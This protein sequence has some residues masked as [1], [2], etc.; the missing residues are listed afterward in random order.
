MRFIQST[1]SSIQTHL[2]EPKKAGKQPTS[3]LSK[4]LFLIED[5]VK[6][7]AVEQDNK[8]EYELQIWLAWTL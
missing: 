1:A 3:K 4:T 8:S 7:E 6:Q 2:V 5:R